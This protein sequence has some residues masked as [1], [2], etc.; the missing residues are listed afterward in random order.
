MILS[1]LRDEILDVLLVR[2]ARAVD[3]R[4]TERRELRPERRADVA[5]ADDGDLRRE[6]RVGCREQE[7]GRGEHGACAVHDKIPLSDQRHK[8]MR[9]G[10][11]GGP[12]GVAGASATGSRR[13]T[14]PSGRPLPYRTSVEK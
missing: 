2:R 9:T 4:M 11:R 8:C 1:R 14:V 12:D 10:Y 6:R 5:G 3:D 7:R 13:I